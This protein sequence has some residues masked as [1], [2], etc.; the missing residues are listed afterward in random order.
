MKF[1]KQNPK[2][3]VFGWN[4][5]QKRANTQHALM[6]EKNCQTPGQPPG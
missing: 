6:A 1:K 2:E 3:V 4:Q 5:K